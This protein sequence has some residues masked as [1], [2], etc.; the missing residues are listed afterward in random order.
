MIKFE[1]HAREREGRNAMNYK[2]V[3]GIVKSDRDSWI[4]SHCKRSNTY[5]KYRFALLSLPVLSHWQECHIG[6]MA[7]AQIH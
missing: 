5:A 2:T 7:L 6:S 4:Q 1:P 3:L